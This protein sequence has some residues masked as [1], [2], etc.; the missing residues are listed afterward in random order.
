[1]AANTPIEIYFFPVPSR[2]LFYHGF[3]PKDSTCT[4]EI[5]R[6]RANLKPRHGILLSL[7]KIIRN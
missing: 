1:V 7:T 2:E 4:K 3:Q 6:E 5:H